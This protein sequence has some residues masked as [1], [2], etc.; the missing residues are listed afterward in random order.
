MTNT[1]KTGKMSRYGNL[2]SVI[3]FD[4]NLPLADPTQLLSII[5]VFRYGLQR[6]TEN[7]CTHTQRLP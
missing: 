1:A 3:W 6:A 4:L 7:S 5:T 2:V